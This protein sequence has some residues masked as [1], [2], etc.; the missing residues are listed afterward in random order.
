VSDP[1]GLDQYRQL[2]VRRFL[3]R[4]WLVLVAGLVLV[5]A[6]GGWLAMTAYLTPGVTTDDRVVS[7]WERIDRLDHG[8]TVTEPNP[9]FETGRYLE[10]RSTYLTAIA[11]QV[12]LTYTVG[13]DASDSGRLNATVDV[14]VQRQGTDGTGTPL[15]ET[16]RPV[17]SARQPLRPGERLRVP[18]T[19]NV[20]AL[21]AR[22]AN[23]SAQL[24][25]PGGVQ[26]A[27]VVA[28]TLEGRVNGAPV[29]QS[30]TR[31]AAVD[32]GVEQYTIA[33]PEAP[34]QRFETA[35]PVVRQRQYSPSYRL[36]GPLLL[37]GGAVGATGVAWLARRGRFELTPAEQRW[38]TYRDERDTYAEWV[39]QAT[40]PTEIDTRPR[41]ETATLGDLVDI[42]IDIDGTVIEA[43]EGG[44]FRVVA[45]TCCYVYEAPSLDEPEPSTAA[46]ADGADE[47]ND[48]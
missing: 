23:V 24:G 40:L 48:G 32:A 2:R 34:S 26:T 12:Q 7:S 38:L 36:G 15:W 17:R 16:S 27:V 33:T 46:S 5:A 47:P 22:T 21:R 42:A 39:H 29:E 18:I 44:T 45:D 3:S 20:P 28:V 6:T 1:T 4:W 35:E 8:A 11:P 9:A 13:Y 25:S 37:A 30:F 43:P 10:N 41:A 19:L 31:T 14:R